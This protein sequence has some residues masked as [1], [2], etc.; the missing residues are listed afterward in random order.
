MKRRELS[1]TCGRC[2]SVI[3]SYEE[4]KQDLQEHGVPICKCGERV[5]DRR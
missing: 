2:G 1:D 5:R 4:E 3:P